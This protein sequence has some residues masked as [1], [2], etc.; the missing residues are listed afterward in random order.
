MMNARQSAVSRK[1]WMRFKGY[2]SENWQLYIL[3]VLVMSY[4]FV[5]CYRPMYGLRM[6]F[7]DYNPI[8]GFERSKYVGF[9]QFERL[10]TG[11]YFWPVLRNTLLLS[12]LNLALG[13]PFPI[14][15]AL[16][17]NTLTN[18]RAKKTIQTITYAPHF[19][20]TVVVVGM[21][22]LFLSPT[23][24]IVNNVIAALGGTPVN[25]LT[26]AGKF[27]WVYVWSDVWQNTGWNAVIYIAALAGIDPEL[28]E[29][30]TV[31]GASR[32]R[33]IWHIDIPGILPTVIILLIMS[34]GSIINVGFEKVN[35]MQNDL[36]AAT[37]EVISTYAYK[38]GL[39]KAEYSYASAV[40]FF[41]S[42]VTL[43]L[44]VTVNFISK[45]VTETSLW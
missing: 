13:M 41:N 29:A 30:A 10:F 20:S 21:L 34:T 2:M 39:Q 36:N 25:F 44:L 17:L 19:I 18:E 35:L 9:K 14:I 3:L 1:R 28:H 32:L 31:D 24:G 12:L 33:R 43:V 26:D 6:A 37:S 38:V 11:P 16:L 4:Y 40:D 42:F 5:F 27:R 23:V 22:K 7:M 15:F 8:L 45:R